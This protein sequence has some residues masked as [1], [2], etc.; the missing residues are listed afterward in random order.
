MSNKFNFMFLIL[1]GMLFGFAFGYAF[2]ESQEIDC[3][4]VIQKN[5]CYKDGGWNCE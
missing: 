5:Q 3:K 2:R 4:E 1:L